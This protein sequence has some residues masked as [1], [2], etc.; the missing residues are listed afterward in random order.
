M[1]NTEEPSPLRITPTVRALSSALR[2]RRP[3]VAHAGGGGRGRQGD[4]EP[5]AD[6]LWFKES[7]AK[8]LRSRDFLSPTTMLHTLYGGG[9]VGADSA[10]SLRLHWSLKWNACLFMVLVKVGMQPFIITARVNN[11][12]R[13]YC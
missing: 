3:G 1:E 7:S 4:G 13:L 10:G 6:K 11:T 12:G 8:N 9:Q 5:A 2:G